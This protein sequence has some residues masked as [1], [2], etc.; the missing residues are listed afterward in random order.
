MEYSTVEGYSDIYKRY[1]QSAPI[2][3]MKLA[4]FTPRDGQRFIES[5]DQDLSRHTHM[6]IKNFLRRVLL[7]NR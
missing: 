3:K 2:A 4:T 7:G 5:L 6:R 1:M